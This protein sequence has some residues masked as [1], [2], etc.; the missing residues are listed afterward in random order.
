MVGGVKGVLPVL[1]VGEAVVIGDALPLTSRVQFD[2]PEVQPS[3][4][5][6]PYWSLWSSQ[7]SSRSAIDGGV[8]ALRN[9]LRVDG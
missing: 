6:Q 4:A 5:T 2:G 3:S 1:D 8:E 7:P 9:Q